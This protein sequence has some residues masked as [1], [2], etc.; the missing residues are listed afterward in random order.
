MA[1]I[2]CWRLAWQADLNHISALIDMEL[3]VVDT[4]DVRRWA[5]GE[6]MGTQWEPMEYLR[7]AA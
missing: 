3:Q 4:Q 1:R 2:T 7:V 6:S 5:D